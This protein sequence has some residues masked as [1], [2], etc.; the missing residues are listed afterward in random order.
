MLDISLGAII[1]GTQVLRTQILLWTQIV[2]CT[3][4]IHYQSCSGQLDSLL[5]H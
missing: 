5:H 2:L 3:Q 4:V 1:L